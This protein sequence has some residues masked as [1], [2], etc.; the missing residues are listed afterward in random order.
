[1]ASKKT[2]S[3][4]MAKPEVKDFDELLTDGGMKLIKS[5]DCIVTS[6]KEFGEGA[7]V[8]AFPKRAKETSWSKQ[9]RY[10]FRDMP[11]VKSQSPSALLIFKSSERFFALNFSYGHVYLDDR[12]TVADFG[13]RV[14]INFVSDERLKSVERSNIAVAIRDL[15]QAASFKDFQSF[16]FDD[17]LDLIRKV[18]GSAIRERKSK[19]DGPTKEGV[20]KKKKKD[21]A[22]QV[23]GSR[24]LRFSKELEI[25]QVPSTADEAL[26]LYESKAYKKTTFQIIDYLAP[27]LDLDVIDD[28]DQLLLSSIKV[29]DGRFE[30]SIPEI[31]PDQAAGYKLQNVNGKRTAF[32]DI[33]LEVY[34][35][36]VPDLDKLELDDL[37]KHKIAAI[38]DNGDYV[39]SSWAIYRALIGS[40][41]YKQKQYALNEGGWYQVGDQI[42]ASADREFDRLYDRSNDP[43]FVPFKKKYPPGGARPKDNTRQK[44]ITV[45]Q[46]E[47]T[48]NQEVS[49]DSGYLLLDERLVKVEGQLGK[50]IEACD[51]M[52][53]AG[54]RLIHVKKSC[55]NSSV[56]SHF[57]KQGSNSARMLK[58]SEFREELLKVILQ[59]Y[60]AATQA[61]V[62]KAFSNL[63]EWTVE[64]QIADILSSNEEHRIPFFSRLTLR[65]EART[66]QQSYGYK[67]RLRFITL[68]AN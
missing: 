36:E 18:S 32:A 3:L 56:L 53:V 16:G 23:T 41:E 64:F 10:I 49:Q 31:L 61:A 39:S 13:L 11:E 29:A 15:A 8:Y 7:K 50:G 68:K 19:A 9:L 40:V 57:F 20:G 66:M 30:I 35:E 47:K 34:K 5:G 65:E 4:F 60:D 59:N 12:N 45:F 55:R 67:V 14:A 1:M 48:Y 46:A 58:D 21:F 26:V 43:Y 28:L 2:F 54:K 37:K 52:D 6:S 27:V 51:L 63:S 17:A 44:K 33:S 62:R 24:S 42:K 22:D 25:D 38:S